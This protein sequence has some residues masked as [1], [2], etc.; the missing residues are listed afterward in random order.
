MSAGLQ[1]DLV[2]A[3]ERTAIYPC[4]R[5]RLAELASRLKAAAPDWKGTAVAPPAAYRGV[6]LV[7]GEAFHVPRPVWT[8]AAWQ[9]AIASGAVNH[10]PHDRI[11]GF[12]YAFRLADEFLGYENEEV[13]L[14]SRL[15]ALTTDHRMSE[16][17]RLDALK[18]LA[19]LDRVEQMSTVASGWLMSAAN[20]LGVQPPKKVAADRLA[21]QRAFRGA[22][23]RSPTIPMPDPAMLATKELRKSRT[24]D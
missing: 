17:E 15:A 12:A 21:T 20:D 5:D 4:Q 19:E 13:R 7:V 3:M 18:D 2:N 8:E 9:S 1:V 10:M 23:V 6:E 11:D 14:V 22:C 24:P 16:A